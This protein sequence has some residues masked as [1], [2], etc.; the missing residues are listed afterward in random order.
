MRLTNRGA[1][2][3]IALAFVFGFTCLVVGQHWKAERLK[4]E[5]GTSIERIDR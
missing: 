2:V 1:L 3:V 4:H 5:Q